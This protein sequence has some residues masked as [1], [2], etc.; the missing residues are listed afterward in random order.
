M[1]T[2]FLGSD[3]LTYLIDKR[4]FFFWDEQ[5]VS[6]AWYVKNVILVFSEKI[7]AKT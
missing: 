4:N 5:K 3:K 6:L 1:Q 2:R 7:S